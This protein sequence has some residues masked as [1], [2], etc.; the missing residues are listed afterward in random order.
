VPAELARRTAAA[1]SASLCGSTVAILLLTHGPAATVHASAASK[2]RGAQL[3]A[4]TG[5]VHCHGVAGISGG[6]GPSLADVRKRRKPAEIYTQ[7]HDGGKS[8]PAFGEQLSD[9]QI[10]DLIKYL[11]S[12]RK[13]PRR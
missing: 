8:M 9:D 2:S 1:L 5:C 12:K 13:A 7:I 6:Q 11:R 10:N 4:T 3:F